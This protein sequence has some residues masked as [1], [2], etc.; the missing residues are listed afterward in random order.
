MKHNPRQ[1]PRRH[2]V[3]INKLTL[4]FIG[5]GKGLRRAK[6]K[7]N[8]VGGHILLN[9]KTYKALVIKTVWCYQGGHVDHWKI[10]GM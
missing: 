3:E 9:F 2:F 4:R 7:Y 5:K 10:N 6:T 1:N 8:K